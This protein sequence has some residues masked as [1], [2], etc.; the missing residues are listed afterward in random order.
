MSKFLLVLSSFRKKTLIK[1]DYVEHKEGSL[2]NHLEL[3][4]ILAHIGSLLVA[5]YRFNLCTFIL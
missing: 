1:L 4:A 3:K 2:V 5:V